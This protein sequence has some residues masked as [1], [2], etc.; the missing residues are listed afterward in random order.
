[1][2]DKVLSTL[3]FDKIRERLATHAQSRLGKAMATAL[4][5]MCE[6]SE[7][8]RAQDETAEA[9]AL[10]LRWNDP[11]LFGISELRALVLRAKRGGV[12]S[13]G[14]LLSLAESLRVAEALQ[15]YVKEAEGGA[16]VEC[17]RQL[18]THS[19]L[20]REISDAILSEEEIADS[21]SRTL[22]GLRRSKKAK[23]DQIKTKL[24]Q[25]MLSAAQGGHLRE[26]L[27]T[28][29]EGRY[30]LPVKAESRR[31]VKG[32]AHDQSA[33]GA[34]VFIEP[35]AVVELNNDIRRL[36]AE[37]QEE[38]QRI[39][40]ALSQEVGEFSEEIGG[41]EALLQHID[42]TFAKAQLALEMKA[43]RPL[44]SSD[45]TL[46][47]H[48]AR[49][50]LLG[51]KVVPID[52]R[53]GSDFNTLIIT[54]PN[55]GGKTVTLKTVGLLT[56]M[57]QAGL[58]IPAAHPSTLGVF[59]SIY[60]D[61][62][63]KQ[64]IE[65]S[66]STFSAS[67]SN[68][69]SILRAANEES[70]VLFDE[71]GGGTD[72]VEGAALAMAILQTLT[73]GE[74][75]TMATTHYSELKLYAL[76]E[77]RVANASVAFD[78]TTL[79]PTYRLQIG[80]PGR[81]NAFEI[82]K[83]LGLSQD[84]LQEAQRHLDQENVQF[85]EVLQKMDADRRETDRALTEARRLQAR[86]EAEQKELDT[87][88]EEAEEEKK[89]ALRAAREE[90][91]AIVSEAQTLAQELIKEA[92]KVQPG[93]TRA[94]D[95]TANELRERA[96]EKEALWQE[97]RGKVRNATKKKNDAGKPFRAG[98]TVLLRSMG[99]KAVLLDAPDKNGDVLLQMGILKINANVSDL[100]HA[101]PEEKSGVAPRTR[102]QVQSRIQTLP[103]QLDV[104]GE[105]LE[106]ALD[107]VDRYLDDAVL[108]GLKQVR[109][110]HGKGTGALRMGIAEFLA[111]D[112]RVKKAQEADIK[113]G[114]AGVTVVE[115]A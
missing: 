39:L 70:L 62:G 32:V 96:R 72:P 51:G 9:V 103:T 81:S 55:T 107:A 92:K 63:D 29:R 53:L 13:P 11:P 31:V 18:F 23:Q 5:P 99:E 95:R 25:I 21:A 24:N 60:A 111:H 102:M 105:R 110:L 30:V 91:R 73:D 20:R 38:I 47:L 33:S 71:L 2:D 88:L 10:V 57:G 76:R 82:S 36:E 37:E 58:Q 66:L 83:R 46:D 80:L 104:R 77:P 50:P 69:V 115:F 34:T 100:I 22:F 109:I 64:S 61:I 26:S 98:D 89:T 56:L 27:I 44:F 52:V 42:F 43:V 12:L 14:Q 7:I 40:A 108:C 114:G 113:E 94:L 85:E 101:E 8:L 17:I 68:I 67:M 49:H 41:N 45:R 87:L 6:V 79:S 65:M 1:M 28:M 74:I 3:E 54:G 93:D 112:R 90:A 59:E 86:Y 19:G 97:K 75:R 84:I 78:V 16:L 4:V 48:R 35:M 106:A 15:D